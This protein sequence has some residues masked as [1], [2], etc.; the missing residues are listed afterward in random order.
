MKMHSK[1]LAG[2]SSLLLFMAFCASLAYWSTQWFTPK[3]RTIMAPAPI[4]Q[5][6]PA[7]AADLFGHA[8]PATINVGNFRLMGIVA[9]NKEADSIAI[10]GAD[11]LPT[12]ALR[13]GADVQSGVSIKEI[14]S[15]Y[16]V[17]SIGTDN[18]RLAL[19]QASLH[20]PAV[21]H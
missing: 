9:V 20:I 5:I 6:D 19:P 17:L 2:L 16:I 14:H 15:T 13:L 1:H 18:Q 10:I 7:L 3:Q 8:S 11:G 4:P 21:G 12:R